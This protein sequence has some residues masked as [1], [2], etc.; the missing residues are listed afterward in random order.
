MKH[1]LTIVFFLL[2]AGLSQA[3]KKGKNKKPDKNP[4]PTS[5]DIPVP[6]ADTAK[7]FTGII[8]YRMT[9]D[10]PAERDSM[11]IIFGEN[12]IG[13]V[14]FTP[15]YRADQV[16]ET[17][18][19]A[20]FSDQQLLL[21]DPRSRTYRQENIAARNAGTEFMLLNYRKTSQ[22]MGQTC[23]E[24]KGEM[25]LAGGDK[26]EAACLVSNL[27]HYP[28][29]MD[30][31]FLNIQPVVHGYRIVL[32]WRTRSPENENTYIMAYKVEPGPVESYFDLSGYTPRR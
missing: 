13:V 18:H 23:P 29:I 4:E 10:D 7:K 11:F 12:Q 1:V 2:I 31:N 19:I 16:F 20:R 6:E 3:Q 21:L 27:Y 5:Y 25:V 24:F 28:A 15:G 17:H 8:K 22:V 26:F 30:Y 32:G 9:S 14:M